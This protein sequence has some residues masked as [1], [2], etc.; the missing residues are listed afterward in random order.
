VASKQLNRKLIRSNF[1]YYRNVDEFKQVDAVICS[2]PASMCEAFIPLNKT[3]IFNPTHR[4]NLVR[5]TINQWSK[6]NFNLN[7]LKSK[8]KLILSSMSRY[9]REYTFHYTGLKEF[10]LY[11]FGGFYSKNIKYNPIRKE[12]LVG[13]TNGLGTSGY[14]MLHE[15]NEYCRNISSKYVF[16][17]IREIYSKYTLS[18]LANHRAIVLFPYAVS[19]YS[20]NDFYVSNIPLFIPSIKMLIKLKSFNDRTIQHYCGNHI[21]I[22]DP[23][24]NTYHKFDPNDDSDEH[25]EYWLQYADYY[26]WPFVTVF[27]SWDDLIDKL[28][29]T[30]FTLTSDK[31]KRFNK[32]K[33][34][35]LLN[36][37]CKILKK[38]NR[39]TIPENYYK[40]LEY[41]NTSSF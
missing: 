33:E 12:I 2:F 13:P 35:D 28:D 1:N 4:Y 6:L 3:I 8:S 9:D 31:I 14:K 20:V 19:T 41:F 27:N 29:K 23:F 40:S 10:R 32:I 11:A 15:L 21:K 25:I 16:K 18:Q 24:N 36:N 26:E 37:W 17:H 38:I 22:L 34:T 30:N 7:I 39:S 5:C